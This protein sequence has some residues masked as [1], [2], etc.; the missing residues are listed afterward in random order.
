MPK[1]IITELSDSNLI[2]VFRIALRD[3]RRTLTWWH[4]KFVIDKCSI[5]YTYS[6]FIR[7]VNVAGEMTPELR[8]II[9][10]Y[11]QSIEA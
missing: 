10:R 3:D 7:K 8:T 1:K 2:K 5:P 6:N 9:E 11:L 4:E